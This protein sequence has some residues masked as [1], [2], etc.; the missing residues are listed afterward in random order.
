MKVGTPTFQSKLNEFDWKFQALD[1]GLSK[2]KDHAIEYL[3]RL[4]N[5][6][7]TFLSILGPTERGKTLL[8]NDIRRFV[9]SNS[10]C[11]KFP[12][13]KK[14]IE[15]RCEKLAIYGTLKELVTQCLSDNKRMSEIKGCGILF[16]EEFFNFNVINAYNNMI[17]EIAF[18]ILNSRKEMAVV[19][20]SNKTESE[21]STIDVRIESRLHRHGGTVLS[22]S[23]KIPMFLKRK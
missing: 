19:L 16:I 21:I 2:M 9:L 12:Y 18:D 20:D 23:D 1:N 11:F 15:G 3:T 13:A 22:I 6:E 5:G 10:S 14:T 7:Y 17:I 8:M 4:H